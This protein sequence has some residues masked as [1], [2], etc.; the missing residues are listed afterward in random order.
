MILSEIYYFYKFV[1]NKTQS[2]IV[3]KST[4][5]ELIFNTRIQLCA[6]V[7]YADLKDFLNTIMIYFRSIYN[8]YFG[9]FQQICIYFIHFYVPNFYCKS[10]YLVFLR[11]LLSKCLGV[12]NNTKI[13]D[14]IYE[15]MEKEYANIL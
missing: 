6:G 1:W 12:W 9:F 10:I 5:L 15:R 7:Y 14:F 2:R 3:S 13:L 8:E 4:F 11:T